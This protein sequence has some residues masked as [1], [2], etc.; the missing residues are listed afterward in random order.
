MN[1]IFKIL[2]CFSILF[3]G[4]NMTAQTYRSRLTTDF[5]VG[6][7]FAQF[8][9][10]GENMYKVP[11]IGVHVGG[12]INYKFYS[13]FQVQTGLFISKKGLR[14][15]EQTSVTDPI[16]N[17]TTKRDIIRV[18]DANYFHV[19][20]NLG[21]EN[22]FTREF[23][24]NFNAGAYVAYGFKGKRT[25][26][27]YETTIIGSNPP[28]DVIIDEGERETFAI[29]SL[30]RF[31]YGLGVS[32]GAIYDIF[33]LTFNYEHGLYNLS[34][35]ENTMFKNRNFSISLGFRF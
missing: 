30:D 13:N 7:N 9:M 32:A 16:S 24:L 15:H 1:T 10:P 4:I 23:A 35:V 25:R 27:G 34:N 29:R 20:I 22:Y 17:Q 21:Y 18:I 6:V 11:K 33:T 26:T 8:Y 5:K 31:D 2:L 14:Q 19:P 28:Q 12:N 3:A